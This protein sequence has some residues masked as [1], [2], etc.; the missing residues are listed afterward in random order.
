MT[1][2]ATVSTRRASK[3]GDGEFVA[4]I[5]FLAP[6]AARHRK[7]EK[8][9]ASVGFGLSIL[10]RPAIAVF[11]FFA[12]PRPA[13]RSTV[14]GVVLGCVRTRGS[15]RKRRE[16]GSHANLGDDELAAAAGRREMVLSLSCLSSLRKLCTHSRNF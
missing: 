10:T 1:S 6:L 3:A 7:G 8:R 16:E 4:L 5:F 13:G 2:T 11:C 9:A 15:E 12:T 14:D